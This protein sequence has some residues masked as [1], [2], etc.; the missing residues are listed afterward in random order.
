MSKIYKLK[1]LNKN[2]NQIGTFQG[3]KLITQEI[4]KDC[5][6]VKLPY[7][8][9]MEDTWKNSLR[10]SEVVMFVEKIKE[11]MLEKKI[12]KTLFVVPKSAEFFELEE[13]DEV[14]EEEEV[15]DDETI[16]Q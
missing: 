9:T 15:E 4:M 6:I 1:I 5:L 3:K 7:D 13:V 16:I 14:E 2:K 11:I 12:D 8:F 10:T